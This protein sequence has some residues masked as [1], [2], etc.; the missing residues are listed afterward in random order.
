MERHILEF[1]PR[2]NGYDRAALSFVVEDDGCLRIEMDA[3]S[4]RTPRSYSP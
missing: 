4:I 1:K 2:V 3:F